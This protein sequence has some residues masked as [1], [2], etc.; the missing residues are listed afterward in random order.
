MSLLLAWIVEAILPLTATLVLAW[1]LSHTLRQ[2]CGARVA[3]ASWLLVLPALVPV[4]LWSELGRNL[5][6]ISAALDART[7][8]PAVTITP[9]TA[10]LPWL[11]IGWLAGALIFLGLSLFR[12]AR[13]EQLLNQH[14]AIPAAIDPRWKAVME[15]AAVPG[16]LSVLHSRAATGPLI[17]GVVRPRLVLPADLPNA[18]LAN[19]ELVLRHEIAH[20]RHGDTVWNAIML[21]G[22]TLFWFHPLIHLAVGRMRQDQE[23]AAD[24]AVT[25]QVNHEQ[26]IAYAQLLCRSGGLE[27]RH[28]GV[29]WITRGSLRERMTMIARNTPR[30]QAIVLGT[31]ILV[32]GFAMTGLAL[33]N[34]ASSAASPE[35]ESVPSDDDSLRAVERVEPAWPREAVING[36]TGHVWLAGTVQ[37]DGSLSDVRVLESE[38]A[39]VFDDVALE[40]FRQWQFESPSSPGREVRQMIR[41]EMDLPDEDEQEG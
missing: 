23:L 27:S 6:N 22:Q 34:A 3:Y 33:A 24:E 40:A 28:L 2:L 32:A 30:R 5:P 14:R 9:A 18:F 26:K 39:G 11:A 25:A 21:L 31:T 20:L 1:A 12:Q 41:F 17:T 8:L 35:S 37:A 13:F 19:G 15:K 16:W 10:S 7:I 36:T 4:W 38:P 29:A